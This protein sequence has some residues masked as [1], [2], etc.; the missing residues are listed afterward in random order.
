MCCLAQRIEVTWLGAW[1]VVV[2]VVVVTRSLELHP[3]LCVQVYLGHNHRNRGHLPDLLEKLVKEKDNFLVLLLARL[4]P[5]HFARYQ[6]SNIQFHE[7]AF[8]MDDIQK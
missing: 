3:T 5:Y 4:C 7:L 8:T 2:V 1:L 6:D